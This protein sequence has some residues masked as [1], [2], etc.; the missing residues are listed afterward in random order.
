MDEK[1]ETLESSEDVPAGAGRRRG[2]G[3]S[4][5]RLI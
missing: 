2:P 3:Y 1:V 5:A 4:S